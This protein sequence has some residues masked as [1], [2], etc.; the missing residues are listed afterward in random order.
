MKAYLLKAYA[1]RARRSNDPAEALGLLTE[2]L[3]TAGALRARGALLL[4]LLLD[5]RADVNEWL[6]IRASTWIQTYDADGDGEVSW[7]DF[8]ATIDQRV[9]SKRLHALEII[10]MTF[11]EPGSG[12]IAAKISIFV[13]LLIFISV[14]AFVAETSPQLMIGGECNRCVE[15][16]PEKA[17]RSSCCV[18]GTR[19]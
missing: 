9:A 3:N 13:L 14:L 12:P 1:D 17:G 16:E 2:A 18:G 15:L 5:D 7:P 4:A 10:F 8:K 11:D 19:A 6:H